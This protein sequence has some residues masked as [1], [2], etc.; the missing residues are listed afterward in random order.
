MYKDT[1]YAGKGWLIWALWSWQVVNL[2]IWDGTG[3]AGGYVGT[4]IHN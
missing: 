2:R 1:Y 3:E 4:E